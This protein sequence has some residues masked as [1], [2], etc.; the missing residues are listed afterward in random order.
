MDAVN[1]VRV[2]YCALLAF[3]ALSTLCADRFLGAYTYQPASPEQKHY[4]MWF[5]QA[6][7]ANACVFMAVA[8][9]G[10]QACKKVLQYNMLSIPIYAYISYK[11]MPE[12]VENKSI[13]LFHLALHGVSGVISYYG[14]YGK[15]IPATSGDKAG[16]GGVLVW[17]ARY[18]YG[19]AFAFGI[20][21]TVYQDKFAET[22]EAFKKPT[23]I[24][25]HWML[26]WGAGCLQQAFIMMAVA[27][28]GHKTLRKAIQYSMVATLAALY[29]CLNVSG[30]FMPASG[31]QKTLIHAVF[32]L[33]GS[34]VVVYGLG[35]AAKKT[36]K[37]Q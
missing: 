35:G 37:Q 23:A 4:L 6:M 11:Y 9:C 2:I 19:M 17:W 1:A 36:D 22:Y 31:T 21:I 12:F 24:D 5:G 15:N 8:Q 30:N 32:H 10:A 14:C 28:C 25:R 16:S 27:Q 7:L 33:V 34:I 20:A 18:C 29:I 13:P 26:W 3:A